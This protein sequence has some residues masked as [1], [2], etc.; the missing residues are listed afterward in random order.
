MFHLVSNGVCVLSEE[1]ENN[2]MGNTI[3]NVPIDDLDTVCQQLLLTG[4]WM[5]MSATC[6]AKYKALSMNYKQ[7][8][9]LI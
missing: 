9:K 8:I 1:S 6:A 2:Y 7:K 5:N 3:L 4:K